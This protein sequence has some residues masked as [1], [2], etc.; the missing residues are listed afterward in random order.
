MSDSRPVSGSFLARTIP[1][2]ISVNTSDD[3]RLAALTRTFLGKFF[4]QHRHA[5]EPTP[6]QCPSTRRSPRVDRVSEMTA[7]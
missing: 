5:Q 1:S 7:A 2:K 3:I 6:K 4:R